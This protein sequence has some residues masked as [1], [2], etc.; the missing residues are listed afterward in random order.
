MLRFHKLENKMKAREMI[1]Q[2]RR[3]IH[4]PS[5]SAVAR[6]GGG[7]SGVKGPGI[8]RGFLQGTYFRD[9]C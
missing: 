1:H 4:G 6:G 3:L 8:W 9:T 5:G 7:G 2:E